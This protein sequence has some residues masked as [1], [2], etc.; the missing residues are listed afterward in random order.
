VSEETAK[1]LRPAT[2]ELPAAA[3]W[4]AGHESEAL[5]QCEAML[6]ERENAAALSLLA[7]IHDQ[8]RRFDAAALSLQR[9]AVLSPRDAGVHRRLANVLQAQGE[10]S[11]AIASYRT[12]LELEPQNLRALNNLGQVLFASGEHTA[13]AQCYERALAISPDYA[14]ALNNL[15]IL[16]HAQG[17]YPAAISCYEHAL[18][19]VPNFVQACHNCGAALAAS[20]RSS[21]ALVY[22]NRALA[23]QPQSPD[24]LCARGKVLHQLGQYEE[25]LASYDVCLGLKA[26]YAEPLINSAATLL[27]LDRPQEARSR[28]EQALRLQPASVE[29]HSNLAG[30][31]MQLGHYEQAHEICTRA[32]ELHPDSASTWS[33]LA[34]VSL[35]VGN[36]QRAIQCCDEAI[37]LQ[38]DLVRAHEQR[39]TALARERRLEESAEAISTILRLDPH[40]PYAAGS[41]FLTR[42]FTCDW[43]DHAA[44][45][46]ELVRGVQADEPVTLPFVL[47]AAVDDPALHLRCAKAYAKREL[48]EP[49]TFA[50]PES[51]PASRIRVAY[52][53][54][55]FHDHATAILAAGLFECHDRTRFET[56]AVSFGPADESP[57]RSR[58]ERAFDRFIDVRRWRDPDVI[59]ML[60]GLPVDIVVDLKGF[61]GDS[62]P[63][64]LA[65]RCAPLQV[66][67]LGYPGTCGLAQLD[68]LI[69][70]HIVLPAADLC[71]YTEQAVWLPHSYQVNDATRSI[72]AR[73]PSRSE[74]GLPDDA[75]VFCCFN[76][77]YKLSPE[78]FAVWLEVLRQVP[79]SVLWLLRDNPSMARNLAAEANRGGVDP[80]RLVFAD[81]VAGPDH[82]ARQ[83]CADLFLDTLPY[84]AHTTASD[85]LWA[86]LPVLTCLGRAFAG[87]VAASLLHAVELPQLVTQ[88]PEEYAQRAV[89]LARNP[90]QLLSWR[91]S[92][93][94]DRCRFPLFDTRRF[95]LHL[96]SAFSQMWQRH[97][98]GLPPESFA[99][100]DQGPPSAA[101]V[102]EP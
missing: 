96:E 7:A 43:S 41:L 13:A 17:E 68:Y 47:L 77:S 94:A 61:T 74:L 79:Q 100:A 35:V 37:A 2:E 84:N 63:G 91:R 51:K 15:G 58:V 57:M 21:E 27:E 98:Q 101:P 54:A 31:L 44:A 49:A 52:V 34:A 55:D 3:L 67:Y 66:S 87:R 23:L 29:A 65:A 82:L 45:S 24:T 60:R 78:T 40:H 32:I 8:A 89:A 6:R 85:A 33:N 38:P 88:T 86:G 48:R 56:I 46:M 36:P 10:T 81:R 14:I 92:L 83:R 1:S 70:D 71:N 80:R 69:A 11:A 5:A 19:L 20:R 25:A 18:A 39:S 62:R 95:C 73:T 53:S 90:E 30:A 59:A 76:S 12:S 22:F 16:R 26:A 75:F 50:W 97:R 9:L 64:L 102:T 93:V 99:V 4:R 72:A 28:S 42:R